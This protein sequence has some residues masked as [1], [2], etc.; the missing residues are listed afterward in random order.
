MGS[1]LNETDLC[2]D[3]RLL[4]WQSRQPAGANELLYWSATFSE[5]SLSG[6]YYS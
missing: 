4:S 1:C 2:D 5:V 3:M 6:G